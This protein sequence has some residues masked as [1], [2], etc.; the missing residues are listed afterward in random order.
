ME[1]KMTLFDLGDEERRLEEELYENG[2]ELTPELEEALADNEEALKAKADGYCR[3]IR[4]LQYHS[5][6]CKDEAARLTEKARRAEKAA[7]RL[8]ERILF[9]MNLFGWNR[10]EGE[11]VKFS[12][13]NSKSLEVDEERLLGDLGIGERIAALGL[14]DFIK[15][16]A[17][18]DKT[19]IK[20]GFA[21]D[22]LP[23]GC[24][25][26]ENESLQMR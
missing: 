5:Q 10:L 18:V 1:K 24:E 19:A 6:N 22:A 9:N 11:Q 20:N 26:S 3:I 17:K 25:W 4:E 2:G 16:T 13:R 21:A 15:V 7:A 12:I 23:E 14:P 8:K